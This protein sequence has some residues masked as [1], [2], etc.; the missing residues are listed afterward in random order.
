M[1]LN[2][3]NVR[4]MS[5]AAER[6]ANFRH[7]PKTCFSF[8]PSFLQSRILLSFFSFLF[9]Y[10]IE[11]E[12]EMLVAKL[13]N[14]RKK[15]GKNQKDFPTKYVRS[16]LRPICLITHEKTAAGDGS[17]IMV[18]PLFSPQTSGRFFLA[19]IGLFSLFYAAQIPKDFYGESAACARVLLPTR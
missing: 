2:S 15:R 13:R 5:S 9:I 10:A 8:S 1:H 19:L 14:V 3:K 6:D 7:P 16:L 17:L 18:L 11:G 4:E 12:G